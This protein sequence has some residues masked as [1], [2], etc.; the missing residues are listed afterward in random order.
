MEHASYPTLSRINRALST[1]LEWVTI[2]LMIM[3]TVIVTLP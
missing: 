3:L 1:V 2:G